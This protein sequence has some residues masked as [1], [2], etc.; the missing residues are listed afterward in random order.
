M[1]ESIYSDRMWSDLINTI[2]YFYIILIELMYIVF[3]PFDWTRTLAPVCFWSVH[4]SMNFCVS[5]LLF[6]CNQ[7]KQYGG[8]RRE[9][10]IVSDYY[11]LLNLVF[12]DI[13]HEHK[14]LDWLPFYLC[15]L[16][17]YYSAHD[18]QLWNVMVTW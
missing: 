9:I 16:K 2:V 12:I 5:E 15:Y 4:N 11:L 14:N 7:Y 8:S 13:S 10:A 1:L 6:L 18:T 17:I 3:V